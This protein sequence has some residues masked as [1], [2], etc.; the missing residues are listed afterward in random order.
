MAAVFYISSALAI[1]ATLMVITRSQIVHALLY[2]VLSLFSIAV[3]FFSIG[4]AFAAALEIIV[5]AGAIMVL[6]VFAIMTINPQGEK[7]GI[8]IA[9]RL[10]AWGL[11]VVMSLIIFGEVLYV[12]VHATFGEAQPKFV[13]AKE[14]G[15]TLFGQYA[16]AVELA[17]ILL[18][19]GLVGAYHIGRRKKS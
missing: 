17:S 5:Y 13:T 4:A 3:A 2:M 8:G 10:R 6:F 11:P 19:S 7:T 12:F 9:T 1:L 18:L 15:I 14:V 16:V